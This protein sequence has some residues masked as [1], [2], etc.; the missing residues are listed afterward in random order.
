MDLRYTYTRFAQILERLWPWREL[1]VEVRADSMLVVRFLAGMRP[2]IRLGPEGRELA[3]YVPPGLAW[4]QLNWG[5][6]EGQVEINGCEWGF[7]WWSSTDLAIKLHAGEIDAV[8][9]LDFARAVGRHLGGPDAE[10]RLVFHG[11]SAI[12]KGSSLV[13]RI[14]P[15]PRSVLDGESAKIGAVQVLLPSLR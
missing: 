9:A 7:Y 6:A 4:R 15:T 2:E 1:R 10:F 8:E 3:C 13:G 12:R 5:Q 14:R 11:V